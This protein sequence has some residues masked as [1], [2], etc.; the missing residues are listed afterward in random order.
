VLLRPSLHYPLRHL[1]RQPN[2]PRAA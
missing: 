1:P 2:P